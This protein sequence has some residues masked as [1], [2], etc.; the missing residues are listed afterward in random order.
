MTVLVDVHEMEVG[1]KSLCYRDRVIKRLHRGR[2][3]IYRRKHRSN[4]E[5]V[6]RSGLFG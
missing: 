2:R 4:I 5:F 1:L 6:V 3:K